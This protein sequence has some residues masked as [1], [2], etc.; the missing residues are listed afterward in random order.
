MGAMA[1]LSP[2]HRLENQTLG[3]VG[4]GVI[5]KTVAKRAQALGIHVIAFDDF[6]DKKRCPILALKSFL[7]RYFQAV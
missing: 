5:G 3:I 7:G 1:A 4:L 2:V 6:V